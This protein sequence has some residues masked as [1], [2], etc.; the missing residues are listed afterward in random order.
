MNQGLTSKEFKRLDDLLAKANHIQ[1]DHI[2]RES[3]KRYF[4]TLPNSMRPERRMKRS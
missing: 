1:L 3:T 2:S 4:N